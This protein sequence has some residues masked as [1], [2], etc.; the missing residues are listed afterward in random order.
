MTKTKSAFVSDTA[1]LKIFYLATMNIAAKWTML[2]RN[3]GTI[4]DHL[5]INLGARVPVTI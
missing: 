2:I 1:L 4:L 3:R 5:M